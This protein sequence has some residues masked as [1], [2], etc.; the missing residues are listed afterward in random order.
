MHILVIEDNADLAANIGDY[1]EAGGHTVDFAG[2]GRH[3]H[4]LALAQR[5]D[6]IVL[7]LV[8][9]GM[10]GLDICFALRA[11]GMDT[12]VLM[13]TARDTLEDKLDGFDTGADDYL[14][15]PFLLEE[16]VVRLRALHRRAAGHGAGTALRV[17]D[18]EFDPATLRACRG[19]RTLALNPAQRCLLEYLM[20]ASDRVVAREEL[21]AALWGD[22]PPDGDALRAHIHLLRNVVDRGFDAKLIRTVRG[23]GYRLMDPDEV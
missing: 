5:F 23:T 2:D 12:P 19:G 9:P 11:A 17:R 6:A 22:D 1:L 10:D 7:D 21:E 8:L 16:L 18:L 3:G 13:L 14:V 15:K 4:E 20:R